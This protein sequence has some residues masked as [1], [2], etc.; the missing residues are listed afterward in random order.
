MPSFALANAGVALS[1]GVLDAQSVRTAIAV[2]TGL[3]VGKPLGILAAS[4]VALR[5]RLVVLPHGLDARHLG[6]LGTV[7]GI[8][9]TMAI[10]IA[11]LAFVGTPLLDAAKVGVLIATAVSALTGL[12][13]GGVLLRRS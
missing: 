8:G 2:A 3:V 5:L 7:S 9:F 6:V 1:H 13:L 11:D 10:F 12:I 4:L